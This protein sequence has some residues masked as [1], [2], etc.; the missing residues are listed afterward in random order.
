MR[1]PDPIRV[2][3][4][5]PTQSLYTYGIGAIVDLPKFAVVVMG[6]DDWRVD[7]AQ[8]IEEPRLLA[9][10]QQSVGRQ[11]DRLRAAPTTKEQL[12]GTYASAEAL[13]G[14]PVAA[15]PRWLRCPGCGTLAPLKSPV[16]Q[17]KPDKYRFDRSRFGARLS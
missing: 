9:A 12:D 3:E 1:S 15:F 14:L 7:D 11:V 17:F 2:G 10:V 8:E 6:L 16:F 13:V 4:I 5:R